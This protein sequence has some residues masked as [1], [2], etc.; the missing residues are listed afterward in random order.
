MRAAWYDRKGTAR[1][2]LVVG[3]HS[4]PEPGAGEVRVRIELSAINPSD[5]KARGGW[6]GNVT[7]PFPRVIPH[8]DGAGVIDAVGAGVD[9]RRLG[10]RVWLYMAQRGRP[11]G[12]AAQWCVVPAERA[13]P[14][15]AAADFVAGACMGVPAMTAHRCIFADG[16][17]TGKVVLVR[18]GAGAVGY[19]AIQWARR[20]GARLVLATVSR[21]D[22]RQRAGDAGA[23]AIIDYKRDNV[24]ESIVAAVGG[25]SSVDRIVEVDLG[26][27]A[28]EDA[29]LLATNGVITTYASDRDLEPAVP[30]IPLLMKDATIRFVLVYEMPAAAKAEA[31]RDITAALADGGL[32]YQVADTFP[33]ADIVT[34]HAMVEGG[35]AV[36]KVLLTLA[37]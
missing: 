5:T 25:K 12:T 29:T 16:P 15:P 24:V 27:N 14:L 35:R 30:F 23:H 32:C 17:V 4:T 8:Q 3:E 13:V 6:A 28:V 34:A 31:I 1:D 33:L 19:Y 36:G 18:G 2:V 22:Q 10:E 11:F 9:S 20:G 21:E 7:M 37:S 26:T